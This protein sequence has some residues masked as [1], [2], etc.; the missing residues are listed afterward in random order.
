MN[1]DMLRDQELDLGDDCRY[2]INIGSVG[3]PRDGDPRACYAIYDTISQRSEVSSP[4]PTISKRPRT[5]CA[6]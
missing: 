6:P 2:I 3:Q 5:K 1:V 4:C